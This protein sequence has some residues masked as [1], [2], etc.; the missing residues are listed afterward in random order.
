MWARR[1]VIRSDCYDPYACASRRPS[2]GTGHVVVRQHGRLPVGHDR[3]VLARRAEIIRRGKGR[4]V[5]VVRVGEL[6]ACRHPPRGPHVAGMNCIGP[7]AWSQFLSQS[8]VPASVS[9]IFFVFLVPS[10]AGPMIGG[11]PWRR[12]RASRPSCG[13]DQTRSCRS[14]RGSSTAACTTGASASPPIRRTRTPPGPSPARSPGRGGLRPA[15]ETPRRAGPPGWARRWAERRGEASG[16]GRTGGRLADADGVGA[17]AALRAG[18]RR[19][20]QRAGRPGRGDQHDD[21]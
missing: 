9:L 17:G 20:Q 16:S 19:D 1:P 13:R 8:S 10:R 3:Q 15:V 11:A 2:A 5:D 7:T 6:V 4:V 21:R 18:Q 12:R 14:R